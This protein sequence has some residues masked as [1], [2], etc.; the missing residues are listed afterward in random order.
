[1]K[2]YIILISI[3][4]DWKSVSRVLQE[5]DLIISKWDADVSVLIVNDASTEKKMLI[6]SNF[7][8]IKS[9]RVMN[10][11]KNRGHARCN[12][13]GLKFLTEKEDFDYVILM[14][15]DGEDLL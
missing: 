1:M 15:G 12:A 5:I 3:Y 9:L 8:N 11:K 2:K 10:M 7:S 6:K 14:D 13:A 4:N